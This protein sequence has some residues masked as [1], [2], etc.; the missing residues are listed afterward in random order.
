MRVGVRYGIQDSSSRPRSTSQA[1]SHHTVAVNFQ[2]Y[3]GL[4]SVAT[5]PIFSSVEVRYGVVGMSVNILVVF[6]S[7]PQAM[8]V[9]KLSLFL[10]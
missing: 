10:Y 8:G 5:V 3:L 1:L 6:S 4:S 9:G 7:R 2:S